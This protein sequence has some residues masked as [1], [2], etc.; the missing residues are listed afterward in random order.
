ME[1]QNTEY[2]ARQRRKAY[3]KKKTAIYQQQGYR[4]AK[5][6]TRDKSDYSA[7]CYAY[8]ID[9]SLALCPSLLWLLVFLAILCGFFPVFLLTPMYWIT[10]VLLF[11]TSMLM[12]GLISV[13]THGQSLGRGYHDLK[14]VRKDNR[15]ANPFIL[16]LREF[17]GIGLPVAVLGYFFNFFRPGC[18]LGLEYPGGA[19]LSGSALYRGLDPGDASG[20]RAAE[21]HPV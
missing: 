4:Q 7:H 8:M 6:L 21:Q 5:R 19:G 3:F 17:I 20:V 15:E 14:V 12:T 1:K 2:S 16:F 18:F 10:L 9:V 11:F 13:K